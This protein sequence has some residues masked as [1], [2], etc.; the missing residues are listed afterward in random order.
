MVVRPAH[1]LVVTPAPPS[2]HSDKSITHSPRIHTHTFTT[3]HAHIFNVV[4]DANIW[5]QCI[6]PLD[7]SLFCLCIPAVCIPG[8][9]VWGH[10]VLLCMCE[11]TVCCC[12]CV[13]ID[14]C[15]DR[16]LCWCLCV[17]AHS[18]CLGVYLS[19]HRVCLCQGT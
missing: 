13:R 16:W 3:I 14:G 19:G 1:M 18:L 10:S 8:V 17:R 6:Y 7:V 11:G 2:A 9:Y 15:V 4:L 5:M 12:V